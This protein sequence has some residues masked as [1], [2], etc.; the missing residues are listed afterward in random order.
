MSMDSPAAVTQSFLDAFNSGDAGEVASHYEPDGVFVQEDGQLVRGAEAMEETLAGFLAMSPR[1]EIQ[2][3]KTIEI[4]DIVVNA[5]KWTLTGTAP[6]G[7]PI[8][9]EGSGFDVM[10]RQADGSWRMILDNPWGTAIL[11]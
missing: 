5:Q 7:A 4:G 10:R 9:M 3:S 1:L 11:D 2:V 6:G 8:V